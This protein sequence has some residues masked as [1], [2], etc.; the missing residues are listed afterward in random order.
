M[1]FPS[2]FWWGTGA[3][4]TQAEGAAPASD[5]IVREQNGNVPV[6]GDGNGFATRYADDFALFASLGL[7]HHRLSIE[8]ARIEPEPGE[9]DAAAVA[10][11]R[12]MLQAAWD[13]GV[14]PWICLHHFTLPRW[15]TDAGGFTVESHRTNEWARH[16]D[17]VAETFGDLAGGWKPVNETNYY[18]WIAAG[19]AGTNVTDM[20]QFKETA[21]LFT[22]EAAARLRQTGKPVASVY[23][24]STAHAQ[25]DTD[26]TKEAVREHFATN[27]DTWI[28]L[29]RDG[30]LRVEGREPVE[31]PDLAGCFDVIGFSYYACFGFKEGRARRHPD[32]A[33]AS[34][35]GYAI[36]PEGLGHVFDRLREELPDT[37][38]LVSELGI[39]TDDDEERAAYLEATIDIAHD[40][41]AKGTDLRGI[42]HWTGVDNYEWTRGYDVRFGIVDIDRNVKGRSAA[43]LTAEALG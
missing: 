8:W 40:A 9:R 22:A 42:F 41:L 36:W 18:P 30:V 19:M 6:S 39:G 7:T 21:H 31:R 11:Y 43:V 32:G 29:F 33:P 20:A 37:P 4:S 25:D 2:G 14:T 38:V 24:L 27:W 5:Y 16:V 35:S 34:Q 12:A 13:N 15:F 1:A 23:G 26:A 17:F 28:G 10:H 3:S